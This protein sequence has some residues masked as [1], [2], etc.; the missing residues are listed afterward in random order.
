MVYVSCLSFNFLVSKNR[1]KSIFFVLYGEDISKIGA[2]FAY[3]RKKMYLC[4][5]ICASERLRE[6]LLEAKS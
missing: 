4:R 6:R 2:K 3:V 5:L 1:A